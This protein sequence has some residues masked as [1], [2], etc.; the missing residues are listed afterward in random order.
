VDVV[1]AGLDLHSARAAFGNLMR[2]RKAALVEEA[3]AVAAR[4]QTPALHQMRDLGNSLKPGLGDELAATVMSERRAGEAVAAAAETAARVPAAG[5]E[6]A[7]PLVTKFASEAVAQIRD[8]ATTTFGWFGFY[9]V[10]LVADGDWIHLFGL[11]SKHSIVAIPAGPVTD[12]VVKATKKARERIKMRQMLLEDAHALDEVGETAIAHVYRSGG[13]ARL[14]EEIGELAADDVFLGQLHALPF[15]KGKHAHSLDRVYRIGQKF[16]YVVVEVKGGAGK[17]GTRAIGSMTA[18]QGTWDYL[19]D[20]LTAMSKRPGEAD[21][22]QELLEALM[23]GRVEYYVIRTKI[24]P[25]GQTL[26]PE[27]TRFMLY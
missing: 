8:W 21:T 9:G 27:V 10:E 23:E 1:G 12:Y 14:S 24:P 15:L 13:A 22:A 16:K 18:Q 3:A 6:A 26:K 19:W 11:R 5:A 7:R 17:L 25:L 4:G 2:L 20:V